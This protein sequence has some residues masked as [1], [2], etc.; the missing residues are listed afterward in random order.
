MRAGLG[1][2]ADA[3]RRFLQSITP[4][5][6]RLARQS[7]AQFGASTSDAED[8][9]QEALLAIH[10][11]RSTWDTVRPITPWLSAIVR[12]KLIDILRRLRQPA[13]PI[14]DLID[15][16][17]AEDGPNPEAGDVERLIGKLKN[18]QQAVVR[19][20][21]LEGCSALEV[22]TRLG[23]TETGVR[24]A[25]HRALKSLAV[26]Y[27]AGAGRVMPKPARDTRRS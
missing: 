19:M 24:V 17:A 12:N 21:S 4:Y 8:A 15:V 7:C 2:D 13:V 11:K 23:M 6:R 16:L 3:Y 1:G 22:A 14:D 18:Q 20:V 9:V 10:L 26:L 27:E 25:L 5:L